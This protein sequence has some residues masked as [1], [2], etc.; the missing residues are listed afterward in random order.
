MLFFCVGGSRLFSVPTRAVLTIYVRLCVGRE[1]RTVPSRDGPN[2][3]DLVLERP[4]ECIGRDR[5]A[6]V[7]TDR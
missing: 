1:S 5:H 7:A 3:I 2:V 6:W 4:L